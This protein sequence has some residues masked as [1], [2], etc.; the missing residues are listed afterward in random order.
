MSKAVAAVVLVTGLALATPLP[1]STSLKVTE[2][3]PGTA[4]SPSAQYIVLQMYAAGQN[5]VNG[6]TVRVFDA[7]GTVIGT[8]TF[9]ANVTNGGSQTRILI[10]T[11]EAVTLFG[12]PRDLAMT[13]LIPLAGGKVCFDNTNVD[14]VAWGNYGP[15]DG[16]VGTPFSKPNCYSGGLRQ[17]QAL[18]RNLNANGTLEAADDTNDS[19]ADFFLDLPAPR[20]NSGNVGAIPASTCGNT[21]V[22]ALEFCDDGN[23]L[24]G[25]GCNASCTGAE[26]C[27]DCMLDLE[28]GE[29]C[30]RGISPNPGNCTAQCKSI[31]APT[32]VSPASSLEPLRFADADTLLW[33][34]A[35]ASGSFT[36]TLYRGTPPGVRL[37]DYGPCFGSEIIDST[38]DDLE[39]PTA[40]QAFTYVVAGRDDLNCEGTLGNM[41]N[42]TPRPNLNPCP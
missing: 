6:Q 18:A 36:F 21:T 14:C 23:T 9:S 10:A 28:A 3:F 25:D 27:G 40:K 11:T 39:T 19:L 34:S 26:V 16:T 35:A 37:G 5:L 32:E 38:A 13:A 4:G 30:E 17:G 2:V 7:A 31:T 12:I 24:G 15:V 20:N 41:S 8:F 33:E 29:C 22:E 1:A 42:G